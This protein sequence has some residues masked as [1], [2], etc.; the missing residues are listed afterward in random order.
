[1]YCNN[2]QT[3]WLSDG[4]HNNTKMTNTMEVSTK[5]SNSTER[6]ADERVLGNVLHLNLKKKWFDMIASGEKK[7]EYREIKA[8]WI[9][10]LKDHSLTNPKAFQEYN[11]V[12]FRNGYQKD[13]PE[14]WVEFRGIRVGNAKAEW[15]DNWQGQVFIIDLGWVLSK[16]V[17]LVAHVS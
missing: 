9:K 14:M 6:L 7:E 1:M 16:P 4:H 12:C 13:A 5:K 10:R 17:Q 3:I 2:K 11:F 8:H 15:S